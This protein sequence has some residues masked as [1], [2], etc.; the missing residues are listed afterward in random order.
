MHHEP[1]EPLQ[2]PTSSKEGAGYGA[3]KD[4]AWWDISTFSKVREF[5]K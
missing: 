2:V 1:I 5:W 3:Q 4:P